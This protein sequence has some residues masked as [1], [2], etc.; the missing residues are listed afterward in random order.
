MQTNSYISIQNQILAIWNKNEKIRT[1]IDDAEEVILHP[2]SEDIYK[3]YQGVEEFHRN[4]GA[5]N[6]EEAIKIINGIFNN[7]DYVYILCNL[8]NK[9]IDQYSIRDKFY[10]I[11][12]VRFN[13]VKEWVRLISL[14]S[15]VS[16]YI[17]SVENDNFL[18]I[19][20]LDDEWGTPHYNFSR[21]ESSNHGTK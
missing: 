19:S 16:F 5:F 20:L 4:Y 1:L 13:H 14:D 15:F 18:D 9:E 8:I 10:P 7:E 3:K 11:F 21:M 6:E 17:F 2:L 12:K